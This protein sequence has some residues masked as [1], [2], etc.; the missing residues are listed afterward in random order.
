[1][2]QSTLINRLTEITG[3]IHALLSLCQG[4]RHPLKAMTAIQFSNIMYPG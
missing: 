4:Q 3:D 1:M 2:N